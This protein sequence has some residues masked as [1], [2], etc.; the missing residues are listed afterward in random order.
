MPSRKLSDGTFCDV[1]HPIKSDF[2]TQIESAVLG[3]YFAEV[4]EKEERQ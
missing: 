3:A 4:E 2:R 1:V